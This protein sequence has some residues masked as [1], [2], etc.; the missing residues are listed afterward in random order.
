MK[1]TVKAVTL[2]EMLIVVLI[3]SVLTFVAVPRMGM[4]TVFKGKAQTTAN[5]IAAAV[6]LC[7]TM[8]ISNA[9]QNRQGFSLTFTGSGTYTGFQITNLQTSQV[10]KTEKLTNGITYSGTTSFWFGPLG[11]RTDT[12]GNLTVS[13]GGKTLVISVV[14]TTGMVKCE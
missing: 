10:V 12:G 13:A 6:R 14:S 5:Q 8:A 11:S 9:A 1:K 3:I 7:R 4:A 2:V